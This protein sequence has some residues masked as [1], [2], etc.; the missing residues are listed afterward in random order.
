MNKGTT[1]TLLAAFYSLRVNKLRAIITML[2]IALGI[3]SLVGMQTAIDGLRMSL[4]SN[5]NSLGNNTFSI[6]KDNNPLTFSRRKAKSETPEIGYRDALKFKKILSHPANV[7]VSALAGMG[8]KARYNDIETNPNISV[9]GSDQFYLQANGYELE[10]GRNFTNTEIE[11]GDNV[12]IIG[13]ELNNLLFSPNFLGIGKEIYLDDRKYL[14]IGITKEKG[15]SFGMSFDKVAVLP[16]LSARKNYS[17]TIATNYSIKVSVFDVFA[18]ESAVAAATGAMRIVR[19]LKPGEENNFGITKSENLRDLLD[20]NLAYVSY[21]AVIIG[22]I[23][24]SGALIA[25]MNIMFVSVTERTREIGTRMA[26]GA[27]AKLIRLQF[28]S[29]ATVIS[30]LGGLFGILLG[31][32]MGNM[33]ILF[34]KLDAALPYTWIAI[35]F[36]LCGLVGVAAGF[37]PARKAAS[38]DPIESLRYE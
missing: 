30:L 8:M 21:A 37:L 31:L 5:L 22:L 4:V 38:L 9:N 23:T 6:I 33:V 14:V 15:S 3:A 2:I 18:M 34:L 17:A 35:S 24:L 27:S 11:R 26:V 1:N 16:L 12:A 20:E 25:L 28:L 29:E 19:K 7:C 10:A 13:R 32:F 36:V